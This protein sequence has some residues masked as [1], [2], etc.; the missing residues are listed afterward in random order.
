M[1]HG[2]LAGV[3]TLIGGDGFGISKL[4]SDSLPSVACGYPRAAGLACSLLVYGDLRLGAVLSIMAGLSIVSM[5]YR[6]N[7]LYISL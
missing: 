5:R 3:V 2:L 4:D 7:T 1:G 6:R